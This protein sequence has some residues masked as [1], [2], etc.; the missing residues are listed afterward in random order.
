MGFFFLFRLW[1]KN[2]AVLLEKIELTFFNH[3]SSHCKLKSNQKL[4][5]L[6]F[7]SKWKKIP[8]RGFLPQNEIWEKPQRVFIQKLSEH[9][10]AQ[11]SILHSR[12]KVMRIFYQNYR[13]I[14]IS[15]SGGG[16]VKNYM[17]I[18][19][20]P[21]RATLLTP[22]IL[23]EHFKLL[24]IRDVFTLYADS[25]LHKLPYKIQ[26]MKSKSLCWKRALN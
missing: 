18:V 8:R 12:I 9:I 17:R 7:A 21:P 23:K 14:L 16:G 22:P 11:R 26:K 1:G 2:P 5:E 20:L 6:Y 19:L 25:L 13:E 24:R 10:W 15:P 4:S 3:F